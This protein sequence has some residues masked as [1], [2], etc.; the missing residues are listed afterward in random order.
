MP[1]DPLPLISRIGT[2]YQDAYQ[3]IEHVVADF[4]SFE[5]HYYVRES[6]ER[7]GVVAVRDN[8]VLLVRQYRLL[9]NRAS[10]ELPG[11]KVD[12]GET[13]VEA[14]RRECLEETGLACTD[15]RPLLYFL[16]GLDTSNNPTHLFVTTAFTQTGPV[17]DQ[18]E[19][20]DQVWVP[21]DEC[22]RMVFA[23]NIVDGLSALGLLAYRL[24]GGH[25]VP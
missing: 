18:R 20:Q 22:I 5:K 3:R 4:G 23:G 25:L 24:T 6:G 8:E 16:P 9:I 1:R 15:L 13:P 11:G 12:D 17:R 10:W 21:V 2:V 14:A 19:V 7:V